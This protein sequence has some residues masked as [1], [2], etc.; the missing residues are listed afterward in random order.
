M[1]DRTGKPYAVGGA[2]GMAA[3]GYPRQTSDIDVF[4]RQA[5]VREWLKAAR[6][7]GLDTSVVHSGTHSMAFDLANRDPRIR[8]DLLYPVEPLY[9]QGMKAAVPGTVGDVTTT[10]YPATWIAAMK[11]VSD[12][13]EALHDFDAMYQRGLFELEAVRALLH[14]AHEDVATY[15]RYIRKFARR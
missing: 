10:V 6:E 12:Q 4:V 14:Y 2:I 13:P 1:A 15:N 3:A 11:F 8:I 7:E 5:D 9:V